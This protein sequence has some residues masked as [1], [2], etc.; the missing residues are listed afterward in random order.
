MCCMLSFKP[1]D[2]CKSEHTE[3]GHQQLTSTTPKKTPSK[4]QFL[5]AGCISPA[6]WHGAGVGSS[7]AVFQEMSPPPKH[8]P[9]NWGLP[10]LVYSMWF[11]GG[12]C[13]GGDWTVCGEGL[14][15]AVL[16]LSYGLYLFHNVKNRLLLNHTRR[17]GGDRTPPTHNREVGGRLPHPP[18]DLGKENLLR[19]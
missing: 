15:R 12:A 14:P 7:F 8:S 10:R 1:A 17:L 9:S 3:N 13:Q 19:R 11:C 16:S 18:W 6:A 4:N 2:Q 5:Y